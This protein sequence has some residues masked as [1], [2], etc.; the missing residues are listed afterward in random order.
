M[1]LVT[2]KLSMFTHPVNICVSQNNVSTSNNFVVSMC[3]ESIE[4]ENEQLEIT[5][6]HENDGDRRIK[7]EK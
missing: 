1:S 6:L 5:S 2:H 3:E 7:D 4:T